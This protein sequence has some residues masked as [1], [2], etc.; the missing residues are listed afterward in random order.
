MCGEALR[1]WDFW[2]EVNITWELFYGALRKFSLFSL[3][4]CSNLFQFNREPINVQH[5]AKFKCMV[6]F[7]LVFM[8]DKDHD[9]EYFEQRLIWIL[10]TIIRYALPISYAVARKAYIIHY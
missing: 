9:A 6:K 3:M 10:S 4:T 2:V 1:C 8:G 7:A 5:L